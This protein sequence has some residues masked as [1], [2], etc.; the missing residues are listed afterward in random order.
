MTNVNILQLRRAE[1]RGLI[2]PL[3]VALKHLFIVYFISKRFCQ[4]SSTLVHVHACQSYSQWWRQAVKTGRSL[5]VSISAR[6]V[7]GHSVYASSLSLLT[8]SACVTAQALAWREPSVSF[9]ARSYD[10]ASPGVSAETATTVKPNATF[11][12]ETVYNYR[13]TS[14][15]LSQSGYF[16]SIFSTFYKPMLFFI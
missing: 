8:R 10:Q 16:L 1:R 6:Q 12:S 13:Q 5:Q 3:T 11:F 15:E 4:K 2:E 14:P 7:S 9:S